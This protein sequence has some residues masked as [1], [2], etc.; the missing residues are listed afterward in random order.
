L[1][2]I[3]SDPQLRLALIVSGMHLSPEFGLTVREIERDGFAIDERVEVLLASDSPE[4]TTKA[5]G[6]G[7]IGFAQAFA[8]IKPDL[9][10]VLGDRF[11]MFSAA[12][13]ALPFKLPVAHI[14]GGEATFG[15]MDESIRHAITKLSH[16]HFV[17]NQV[18]ADRVIQMGE[19]AERVIVSGAPALDLL[20]DLPPVDKVAFSARYG[21][22]LSPPPLLVTYHP[23]TL[24]LER[25]GEQM[26]SL[27]GA[28]EDALHPVIFTEPN[29]DPGNFEIRTKIEDFVSKHESSWLIPNFGAGRYFDALRICAA[30][31]GNSSSGIIEAASFG[32]PVVNIGTRQDGRVRAANVIDVGYGRAEIAAAILR[33]L[34]LDFRSRLVGI[35]NPYGVGNAAERIINKIKSIPLNDELMRKRFHDFPRTV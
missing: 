1:R 14:H 15:M 3:E 10:L 9:L 26:E 2:R 7:L 18:Y 23:V 20:S 24:E 21:V 17:S 29:A 35:V 25:T 16:L 6:L 32:L 30:M 12:A 27:L 33:A 28:L 19:A 34:S 4:G 5:M 13:A 11:E 22:E 31:V 8:R